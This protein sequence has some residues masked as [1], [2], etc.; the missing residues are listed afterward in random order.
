[1]DRLDA[2]RIF[3]AV[4]ESGGFAGAARRLLISPSAATR[5][6]ASLEE[7][8]GVTLLNRTTRVVRLTE[9]GEIFLDQCRRI[10]EDVAAAE[11]LARGEDGEP[12]G[13]LTIT[14]PVCFGRLNVLPV[15]D[16]LIAAHVSLSIRMILLDR[17]VDLIQEGIDIG[18]R[19]G[20]LADSALIATRVGETRRVAVASPAYLQKHGAPEAPADLKS[21]R[22]IAFESLEATREWRFGEDGKI[23][24]RLDSAL[25]VNTADAAIA[26]AEAGLGVTRVLCYQAKAALAAGRL[27]LVLEDF[28]PAPVPVSLIRPAHRGASPNVNAF[29]ETARAY[30][31][32]RPVGVGLPG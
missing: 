19:I 23:S 9:R 14:A 8:L 4:A 11:R 20:P 25:A 30:F 13:R 5:A 32:E 15:I 7:E 31:R 29:V 28:A 6:V 10:L 1:M 27:R 22:I 2:M 16:R 3:A 18:V 17:V 12:R 26:A 24:V 21:H